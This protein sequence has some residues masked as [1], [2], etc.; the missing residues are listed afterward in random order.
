MARAGGPGT[1]IAFTFVH[2]DFDAMNL[3]DRLRRAGLTM[4]EDL[5]G[6]ALFRR[7]L[8]GEP[9]EHAWASHIGVAVL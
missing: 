5:G 4:R 8:P 6:D 7:Y 3:P 2:P 1:R 9:H